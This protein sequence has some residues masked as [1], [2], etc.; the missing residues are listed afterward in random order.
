MKRYILSIVALALIVA[1]PIATA[2]DSARDENLTETIEALSKAIEAH[3]KDISIDLQKEV[4]TLM[5]LIDVDRMND[6]VNDL[7]ALDRDERKAVR[8][9]LTHFRAHWARG[10]K[11]DDR[12]ALTINTEEGSDWL[13]KIVKK[14][15]HSLDDDK[16]AAFKIWLLARKEKVDAAAEKIGKVAGDL[17]SKVGELGGQVGAIAEKFSADAV[18][19]GLHAAKHS[20]KL[21]ELLEPRLEALESLSALHGA[22]WGDWAEDLTHGLVE[23]TVDSDLDSDIDSDIGSALAAAKLG[24]RISEKISRNLDRDALKNLHKL[25]LISEGDWDDF[26]DR[27]NEIVKIS[28]S[29]LDDLDIAKDSFHGALHDYSKNV[30]T[31]TEHFR[32]ALELQRGKWDD[33]SNAHR[34]AIHR[35]LRELYGEFDEGSGKFDEARDAWE[36]V[37]KKIPDVHKDMDAAHKAL[38]K[39]R[40]EE[41]HRKEKSIHSRDDEIRS[42]RKEIEELKR[43]LKKMKKEKNIEQVHNE[44]DH[45]WV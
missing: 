12:D 35:H 40:L 23:I 32:K 10:E 9:A 2:Q 8:E 19:M 14:T 3:S 44:S 7:I 16:A 45:R 43:E 36:K 17:G 33:K 20:A 15:A 11:N 24:A 4:S 30:I 29:G 25:A 6:E 34:K 1:A 5:D 26:S 18:K 31:A 37:L 28:I 21:R 13:E 22:E 42:L 38:E 27:I 39:T 41:L